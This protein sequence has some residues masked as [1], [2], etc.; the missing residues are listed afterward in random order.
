MWDVKYFIKWIIVKWFLNIGFGF[1]ICGGVEYGVGLYVFFV[2]ENFVVEREG[3]L[4][5]DYIF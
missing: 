4:F 1:C 3:F 5:G 2:D